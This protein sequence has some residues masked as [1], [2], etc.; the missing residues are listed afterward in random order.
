MSRIFI[1]V[2]CSTFFS[3]R[4]LDFAEE[5]G[6]GYFHVTRF[7][8]DL[9]GDAA[10]RLQISVLLFATVLLLLSL[11]SWLAEGDSRAIKSPHEAG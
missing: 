10:M 6:K 9:H 2:L 8:L 3:W 11:R 7:G 1:L 4:Y 5:V